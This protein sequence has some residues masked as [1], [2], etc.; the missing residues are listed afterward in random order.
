M[1]H[2]Q[3][4]HNVHA[5]LS[6]AGCL[7]PHCVWPYA[8]RQ[9]GN[10]HPRAVADSISHEV[11]HTIGLAH[12]P[13]GGAAPYNDGSG[14]WGPLLGLPYGRVLSQWSKGTAVTGTLQDDLSLISQQLPRLADDHGDE[15]TTATALCQHLDVAGSEASRRGSSCQ[16]VQHKQ[17]HM[18]VAQQRPQRARA[19][20]RG[21]ISDSSDQDW[22]KVDVSSAG[23]MQ[24]KLQLPSNVLG[25]GINNLLAAVHIIATDG[26][27]VLSAAKPEAGNEVMLQA[28]TQLQHPGRLLM[29]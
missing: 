21:T 5:S 16:R 8:C 10:G 9:L 4:V 12:F 15:P 3:E 6:S 20:V 13:G 7:V 28:S 26:S 1:P 18:A 2:Q 14:P 25:Y 11:G 19:L 27:Q 17:G 22:F 24:V 23:L 29:G